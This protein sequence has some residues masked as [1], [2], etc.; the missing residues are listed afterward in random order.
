VLHIVGQFCFYALVEICF[1]NIFSEYLFLFSLHFF[2][3][4]LL[5]YNSF[6]SVSAVPVGAS[7]RLA[8]LLNRTWWPR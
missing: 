7:D 3:L 4:W 6:L 1:V 2:I 5:T 8:G